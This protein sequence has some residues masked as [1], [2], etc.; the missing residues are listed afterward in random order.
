[1]AAVDNPKKDQRPLYSWGLG[2][3]L[4]TTPRALALG[5][6]N[7]D[8]LV[9]MLRELEPWCRHPQTDTDGR[10]ASPSWSPRGHGPSTRHAL[11][12]AN[13][14]KAS[15]DPRRA[16]RGGV[17]TQCIPLLQPRGLWTLT[18]QPPRPSK[19]MPRPLMCLCACVTLQ[20]PH[21]SPHACASMVLHHAPQPP[22]SGHALQGPATDPGASKAKPCQLQRAPTPEE[23][24]T[25]LQWDA[26]RRPD[27]LQL[28]GRA[29]DAPT[30]SQLGSD[31]S[32]LCWL[33]GWPEGN[34]RGTTFPGMPRAREDYTSRRAARG[35]KE[36]VEGNRKKVL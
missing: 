30:R 10:V 14:S 19:Q 11:L 17:H 26:R 6:S 33:A 9:S 15:W 2:L 32:T 3:S 7:P 16:E 34:P 20:G 5:E 4:L 8:L 36:V 12:A 21:M 27:G 35:R 13:H 1:M 28:S 31:Q 24:A 18:P 22:K 23:G 29:P 25:Q